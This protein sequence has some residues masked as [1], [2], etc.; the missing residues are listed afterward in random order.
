MRGFWVWVLI[1]VCAH[2]WEVREDLEA[3][4][5]ASYECGASSVLKN[6]WSE[7]NQK[8]RI[9]WVLSMGPC[10]CSWVGGD[11]GMRREK[12]RQDHVES[13]G[14]TV[15]QFKE[16]SQIMFLWAGHVCQPAAWDASLCERVCWWVHERVCQFV[17]TCACEGDR[18]RQRK[19]DTQQ[20]PEWA[21]QDQLDSMDDK[22][23]PQHWATSMTPYMGFHGYSFAFP[24]SPLSRSLHLTHRILNNRQVPN[25]S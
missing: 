5:S 3:K 8:P 21:H 14:P 17:W 2:G 18:E 19:K 15:T 11:C 16:Q 7:W 4:D 20:P 24:P 13:G 23:N 22:V 1:L 10:P 12:T 6:G 9:V 25:P